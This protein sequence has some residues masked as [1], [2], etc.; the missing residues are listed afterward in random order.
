ML[1]FVEFELFF[2]WVIGEL[3]FLCEGE[4]FLYGEVGGE[5]DI[6]FFL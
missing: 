6:C 1:E 3:Y 2:L 5:G 4:L